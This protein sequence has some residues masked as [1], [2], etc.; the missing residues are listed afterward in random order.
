MNPHIL[1]IVENITVPQDRRVWREACFARNCGFRVSVI[2]P[3][4]THDPLSH[5]VIDGIG[6]Y[7]HPVWSRGSGKIAQLAEYGSALLYEI[8]LSLK[9]FRRHPFQIIHGANPPDHLFLI[10]LLF[11]PFGVK[12]VFDHHDLAPELYLAK[13]GGNKSFVYRV[14]RWMERLSC[15]TAQAVISTNRSYKRHVVKT[16]RIDPRKVFIVRND[17][18]V[19]HE[20]PQ[21]SRRGGGTSAA[22]TRL[23]YLGSIN[24]QDGVDLLVRSLHILVHELG[25]WDI[26]CDILGDGDDLPRVRELTNRLCMDRHLHFAGFVHDQK[27][28]LAKIHAAHICLESAPLNELN[29][30]STFIKIMEYMSQAKPIVAFDLPETRYSTAGAALLVPPNDVRDY[31][32]AIRALIRDPAR[33]AELGRLGRQRIMSKL[34][35]GCSIQSLSDAYAY[36]LQPGSSPFQSRLLNCAAPAVLIDNRIAV[37]GSA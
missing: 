30:K 25:E 22:G 2:A 12:F 19:S 18:E 29:T 24:K 9:I 37:R 4:S 32:L 11:R 27:V 5:E 23:L 1:F 8:L 17:P 10:A 7:R 13:Y 20:P 28:L 6:I 33:Q 16:H 3:K 26:R 14:L 15:L 34:N 35:W 21:A 36:L 31:A